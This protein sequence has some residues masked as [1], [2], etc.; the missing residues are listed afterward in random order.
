MISTRQGILALSP[1]LIFTLLYLAVSICLGDFYKMPLAVAFIF[2]SMWG[3]FITKGK[4]L[5]ERIA[6]FSKGAA[7]GDV[8]YMIWIF[9]LAGAFA[10]LAKEIGAI[11]ATVDLTLSLLPAK[12]IAPCL[13][14]AACFVSLSIGTSVGT[15]VALAPLALEI[16]QSTGS[17][18]TFFISIVLCGAFFGDNLSFISDTTI[19]ATRSQHCKMNEKFKANIFI[20]GPAAIFTIIIYAFFSEPTM[21][22]HISTGN[23]NPLLVIPYI[24]VIITACC[25]IN[26]LLVLALGLLSSMV[27]AI[28]VGGANLFSLFSFM[29]E[30]I[31]GMGD[32]I[33]VTLLAAGMFELVRH[34][35][36]LQFIIQWLTKKIHGTRGAQICIAFLVSLV[37]VCTANNTIAIITV[38]QIAKQISDQF[39]L[40]NRKVASI[41][42]TCSCITQ[43]LI[44]YG[45]QVLWAAHIAGVAPVAFLP[46]MYYSWFLI[47]MVMVAIAIKHKY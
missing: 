10:T 15:I 39:N 16:A 2:A 34:A 44:P 20:A 46:Y 35:G 11:N 7:N 26:V 41:L 12:Y 21:V 17:N 3:L 43:S 1:M 30:G 24:L 40:N 38:G 6:I 14:I 27:L 22:Q 23:S 47:A 25:G 37:N 28:F 19:A 8:L 31:T 33:E 36:G 9:I 4:T 45:A 13:F 18:E 29:G 5:S 32:L 42:D